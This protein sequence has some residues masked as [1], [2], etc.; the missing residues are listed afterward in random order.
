MLRIKELIQY[1]NRVIGLDVLR[2]YAIISVLIGHS[3]FLISDTIHP[4]II[5]YISIFLLDGVGV[6]FVLSGYLIGGILLRTVEEHGV[7]FVTLLH[8]WIRRWLRTLPAYFFV[9]LIIAAAYLYEGRNTISEI[10]YYA[11]FAQNFSTVPATRFFGESWSLAVEEWF[12]LITP[13]VYFIFF[14]FFKRAIF[15]VGIVII[16]LSVLFRISLYVQQNNDPYVHHIVLARLDSLMIG[17][18][19][20]G[21]QYYFPIIFSKYSKPYLFVGLL[22]LM[23]QIILH[24]CTDLSFEIKNFFFH[25]LDLPLFAVGVA[26]CFPAFIKLEIRH[27]RLKKVI[28]FISLISYSLY[29]THLSIVQ[30]IILNVFAKITQIDKS[31]IYY[32]CTAYFLYFALSI[33]LSY[34]MYLYI[35]IPF[36][37][38]RSSFEIDKLKKIIPFFRQWK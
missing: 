20:S 35:E 27:I 38:K 37:R 9:L 29:L 18:L 13:F 7:H 24:Q 8:F 3:F 25:H 17:V 19:L 4:S 6:F 26:L 1:H 16:C 33:I 32:V 22:I 23:S 28:V 14:P 11:F 34:L 10:W 15:P 5:K 2:A 30:K 21:I 12:Y 36:M 31:S